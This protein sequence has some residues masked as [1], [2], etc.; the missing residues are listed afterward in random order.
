MAAVGNPP[1]QKRIHFAVLE[2]T[3][4]LAGS[5]RVPS[6]ALPRVDT[7]RGQQTVGDDLGA[8]AR[9]PGRDDAALEIRHA[10]D[11]AAL[12]N[13]Q[14]GVVRVEHCDGAGIHFPTFGEG[15]GA[16]H[17]LDQGVGKRERQIRASLLHEL[18]V[19]DGR[20]GHFRR[21]LRVR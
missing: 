17:G 19:V 15:P 5:E 16:G 21:H 1:L 12:P 3:G 10:R 13:H 11:A 8:A 2:G 14:V 6:D 20:T 9:R 4:R 7:S 18:E